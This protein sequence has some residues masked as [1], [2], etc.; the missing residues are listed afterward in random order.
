M[1]HICEINN[2]VQLDLQ[3]VFNKFNYADRPTPIFV[4][5]GEGG[6]EILIGELENI[7]D[8]DIVDDEAEKLGKFDDAVRGYFG[9]KQG[10]KVFFDI[11]VLTRGE[12][13]P[14]GE[15]FHLR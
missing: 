15:T 8:G 1:V 9:P 7:L 13:T 6:E 3:K 4:N 11:L 14:C 2:K 10:P 12:N 5:P